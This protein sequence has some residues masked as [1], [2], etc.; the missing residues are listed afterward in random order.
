MLRQFL[1]RNFNLVILFYM[2]VKH[3]SLEVFVLSCCIFKLL[4]YFLDLIME[5]QD[6][7]HTVF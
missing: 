7:S 6:L 5:I 4:P 2:E 1:L 3:F